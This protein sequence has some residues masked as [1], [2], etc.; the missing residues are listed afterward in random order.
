MKGDYFYEP[1]EVNGRL[2][3]LHTVY[4][5]LKKE[6]DSNHYGL[7]WRDFTSYQKKTIEESNQGHEIQYDEYF[8]APLAT[9]DSKWSIAPLF[10]NRTPYPRNVEVLPKL[11]K[12]MTWLGE[13][14]YVGM[15]RL[16]D[17]AQLGWHYDPDPNP[18]TVRYRCQVP[19]DC[20]ISILSVE[21]EDRPQAEGKLLVFRSSAMHMVENQGK[22][23]RISLI[24]DVFREGK[25][26]M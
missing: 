25:G 1:E 5:T 7:E 18:S 19:F 6:W 14:M 24:F 22:N 23:D 21:S 12:T 2:K 3:G 11:A 15:A 10:F 16:K 17:N 4:P 26:R 8:T 20:T 13:T 9:E